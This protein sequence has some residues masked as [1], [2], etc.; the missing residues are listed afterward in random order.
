MEFCLSSCKNITT[1]MFSSFSY[2]YFGASWSLCVKALLGQNSKVL[3]CSMTSVLI[4]LLYTQSLIISVI[5]IIHVAI[6]IHNVMII[7]NISCSFLRKFFSQCLSLACFSC[8]LSALHRLRTH[9]PSML[10]M[11]ELT[12]NPVQEEP[13]G[14]TS[15][16]SQSRSLIRCHAHTYILCLV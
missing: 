2:S 4:T 7:H 3:Q 12:T 15:S 11:Q 5:Y 16:H 13:K 8:Q 1:V 14:D 9:V 6:I 10:Q